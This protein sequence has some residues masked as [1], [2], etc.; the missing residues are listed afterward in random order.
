M[1]SSPRIALVTG[2]SRGIGRSSALALGANVVIDSL[3]VVV[4]NAGVE[5]LAGDLAGFVS[6]RHLLVSGGAPA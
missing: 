2:A 5:Y 4:A 6:C 3:D 1:T